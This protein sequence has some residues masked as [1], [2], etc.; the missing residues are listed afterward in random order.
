MMWG[1]SLPEIRLEKLCALF[2]KG[3]LT[4]EEFKIAKMKT[5]G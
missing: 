3:F 1:P 2:E 4:E 5:L